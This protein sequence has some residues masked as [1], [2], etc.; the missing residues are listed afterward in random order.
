MYAGGSEACSVSTGTG[1]SPLIT[2]RRVMDGYTVENVALETLPGLFVTGSLYRP[3]RAEE[4]L[5]VILSPNGHFDGGRYRAD[6]QFR[7]ATLARMGAIVFSYD[8]FGWGESQLQFSSEYH[9]TPLAMIVQ[10]LNGMRILDYLIGL[11]EADPVRVGI[12]GGS[13]GGS[14]TMLLTALDDRIDVTVPVVMLSSYFNGGCPCEIGWPVHVCGGGTNNVE[15]A[16]MAAPRPQ[17][18]ISDGNDWTAHAPEV[19]LPYLERIYGYYDRES[20]IKN[21]HL[22]EEGHDYGFSK[23]VAINPYC[24]FTC[25]K[26]SARLE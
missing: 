21:V 2:A 14:Q 3:V 11:E 15:I 24:F 10:I 6:Q 12:T 17:L 25:N 4:K 5:P 26:A 7:M 20:L 9:R 22:P 19:A 18:V 8:L 16:S 13:G 1:F 23:R